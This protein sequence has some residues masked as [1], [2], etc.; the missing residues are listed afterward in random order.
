MAIAFVQKSASISTTGTA[1]LP[2]PSTA[3]NLL[4]AFLANSGGITNPPAGWTRVTGASGFFYYENNPGGL[5]SFNFGS[6]TTSY[7]AEFSGVATSSSLD[8]I[9]VNSS[10]ASPITSTTTTPVSQAGSLGIAHIFDI[11]TKSG[12]ATLAESSGLTEMTNNGGTSLTCHLLPCYL[13]S[14]SSGAAWS[15]SASDSS[16]S[17]QTFGAELAVFKPAAAAPPAVSVVTDT[18]GNTGPG[19][20]YS[21]GSLSF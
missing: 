5:S 12:T 4:V 7:I 10:S 3:G 11:L 21:D 15:V 19:V 17:I 20:S 9:H 6:P 14:P 18:P 1:T 16:M 8:T 2:A 13:I